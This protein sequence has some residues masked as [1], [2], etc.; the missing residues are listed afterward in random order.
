M[1]VDGIA[2]VKGTKHPKEARLYYERVISEF[3]KSDYAGQ[4]KRKLDQL[5]A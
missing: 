1:L 3:P 5:K 2:I 4:A